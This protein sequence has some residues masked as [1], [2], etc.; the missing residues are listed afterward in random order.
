MPTSTVSLTAKDGGTFSAYLSVPENPKGPV[1][2]VF[3]EIFGVNANIRATADMYADAGYIAIAP[4]VFWR[5]Q[6]NVDLNPGKEE[7]RNTAMGL[8]QALDQA[9]AVEDAT[10]ALDHARSLDGANGEAAAVGYCL[11][12]KL[13]YLMATTGEVKAA[14]SYYGVAIQAALDELPNI[15][16]KLLLHIAADDHLCPPEAQEAI[17]K[18][19]ASHAD[20]VSIQSHAGVGHAFAR[21]GAP[22]YVDDAAERAN[23]ETFALFSA[24][25]GA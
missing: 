9:L 6:P 23:A 24:E 12:G 3:Q 13:A 10:V 18:A 15:K 1:V 7:D 2:V 4:D 25:L 19:V 8:M 16:G 22:T 20:R 11:G 17:A 5:Q 21:I 14:A